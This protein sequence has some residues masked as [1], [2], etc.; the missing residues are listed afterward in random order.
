MR[1]D[2][3]WNP[4]LAAVIAR[5]GHGD[6]VVIADPGLPVPAG[7]ET[8]DLVWARNEPRFLPV[9]DAVARELTIELASAASEA[10]DA[11]RDD[12]ARVLPGVRIE[13]IPHDDLKHL[14]RSAIVV[15][16]TGEATPYSN[17]VLHCGVPF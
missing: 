13:S 6:L 9:V 1:D 15:V 2:G 7:V 14:V 10:T 16:R 3:I 12:L 4:R 8:I 5:A 11:G 17:V